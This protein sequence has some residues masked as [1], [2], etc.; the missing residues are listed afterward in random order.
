MR[1]NKKIK[2]KQEQKEA[3]EKKE[4]EEEK[5]GDW[6]YAKSAIFINH[7]KLSLTI[8]NDWAYDPLN[9]IPNNN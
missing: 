2:L 4:A 5:K 1:N 9:K 7:Q 8:I 6:R 3:L